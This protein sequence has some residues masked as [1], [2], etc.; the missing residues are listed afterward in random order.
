[1]ECK[2]HSQKQAITTCNRCH[3]PLC[4]ECTLRVHNEIICKDCLK[5][6]GFEKNEQNRT[7]PSTSSY[8]PK[9]SLITFLLN[10]VP[11][12]S[13]MYLGLMKRGAMILLLFIGVIMVATE[14]DNI[15]IL[16]P[17]IIIINFFDSFKIKNKLENGEYVA[18]NLNDVGLFFKQ[19]KIFCAIAIFL[20][21]IP[22]ILDMFDDLFDNIFDFDIFDRIMMIGALPILKSSISILAIIIIV[23]IVARTILK[24]VRKNEKEEVSHIKKDDNNR[25]N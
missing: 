21:T 4:E 14:I 8:R 9:S 12:L 11:G 22:I 1:M 13:S 6:M 18:D 2:Y 15:S 24:I 3:T 20:I 5:E 17:V 10:V 16:I 23:T 19:N 7:N 25:R